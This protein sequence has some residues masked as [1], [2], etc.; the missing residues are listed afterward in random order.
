MFGV[1]KNNFKKATNEFYL[2]EIAKW[3]TQLTK[4][5]D[6]KRILTI[7]NKIMVYTNKLN[8]NK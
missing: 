6:P 5:T 4:E 2:K 1:R 3:K 8:A 7:K